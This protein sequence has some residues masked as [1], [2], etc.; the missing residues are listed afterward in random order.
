[1]MARIREQLGKVNDLNGAGELEVSAS[2]VPFAKAAS[3]RA[4][5]LEEQVQEVAQTVTEMIRA[6][7]STRA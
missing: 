3:D 4:L 7:G 5:S 6:A 2:T 1:M